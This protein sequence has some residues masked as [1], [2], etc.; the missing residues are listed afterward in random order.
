MALALHTGAA[1][2]PSLSPPLPCR[3]LST[4]QLTLVSTCAVLCSEGLGLDADLLRHVLSKGGVAKY[5]LATLQARGRGGG[6]AGCWALGMLATAALP[7]D[8]PGCFRGAL[9]PCPC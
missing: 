2:P 8:L 4:C 6:G 9:M 1:L 3:L 5:P 7:A